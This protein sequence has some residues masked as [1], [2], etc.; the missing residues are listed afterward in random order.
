MRQYFKTVLKVVLSLQTFT[1]NCLF[2]ANTSKDYYICHYQCYSV[3]LFVSDV[4][5]ADTNAEILLA[6]LKPY[7]TFWASKQ[8][9]QLTEFGKWKKLKQYLIIFDLN[10]FKSFKVSKLFL[11]IKPKNGMTIS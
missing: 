9:N 3:V 2:H 5:I 10:W 1:P 7:F 8:L 4:K 11:E 6:I